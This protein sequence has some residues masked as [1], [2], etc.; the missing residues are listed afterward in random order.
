MY[1]DPL[2]RR[3][4]SGHLKSPDTT[5]PNVTVVKPTFLSDRTAS[6]SLRATW[7]GHACYFIEFPSGLRVLFDPVFEDRCSPF[8]FLGP[9]RY[10]EKPCH[11]KDIP[12]VDAI[13]ISHSHYGVFPQK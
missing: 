12:V 2:L 10:T 4:L 3:K 7:L 13:V 9:K 11:I 1:A 5:P 8:S 6:Q